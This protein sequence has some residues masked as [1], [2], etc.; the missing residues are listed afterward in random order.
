[1]KSTFFRF[2]APTH[3]TQV[4]LCTVV[5][6]FKQHQ[7]YEKAYKQLLHADWLRNFN[8][9]KSKLHQAALKEHILRY[10]R[11]FDRDAGFSLEACHRYSL[12]G[13]MG[14]KVVATKHWSKGDQISFL[15]GCIAELSEEEER[16]LLVTGKNDF[17]VMFSCRKNCAQLWLGSAAYINH[18]CR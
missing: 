15:I 11:W 5:K 12:E 14:A 8:N 6:Q 3:S 13:Q 16:M 9:R 18:D 7:N 4:Y 17:S 10:L 2:R 1:M